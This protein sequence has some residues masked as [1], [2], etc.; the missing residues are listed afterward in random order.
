MMRIVHSLWDC[1]A[2]SQGGPWYDSLLIAITDT[3]RWF[4]GPIRLRVTASRL[5]LT[6]DLMKATSVVDSVLI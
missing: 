5:W 1:T 4:L 3:N 2:D 6:T